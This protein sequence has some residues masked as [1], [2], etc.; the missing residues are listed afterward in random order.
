MKIQLRND[1][2]LNWESY[3]P[4][5]APGEV[6]V[7]IT[8]GKLK[9]GNGTSTWSQLDYIGSVD[10][11][12]YATT[13]QLNSEANA[14]Q[15]ADNNLQGQIDAITASSDV[16]DIVGTYAELQAYDTSKLTNAD[17][18][19]VLQDETHNDETT[20]YRWVITQNVGAW[21]LIGEEGPY[22]TKS[23]ADTKFVDLTSQ[24]EITG[25]KS[26]NNGLQSPS[27]NSPGTSRNVIKR[28][29]VGA[30]TYSI[31]IGDSAKTTG[32]YIERG[33]GQTY[34]NI[35]AGNLSSNLPT[36]T[37]S[38]LGV[39]KP[40][41]S[42]ITIDANGVIS[43]QAGGPTYTE[44]SGISI[45]NDEISV[46]TSVVR[47]VGNQSIAGNKTFTGQ[48]RG[49]LRNSNGNIVILRNGN[50]IYIG[51]NSSTKI[52]VQRDNTHYTNID[53]GNLGNY[54]S[55]VNINGGNA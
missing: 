13:T 11:S 15:L 42:T 14:R 17:I 8:V 26:F 37:A 48:L 38:N 9:V 18:V 10:L 22:Y 33:D 25:N 20:Y 40:D 4:V 23:Q 6:G 5:L 16:T 53:S 46:D 19:K 49:D 45:T 31:T 41:G 55:A 43:S 39:V 30:D 52:D 35:D 1:T 50:T 24:Q 28:D 21:S 3:N 12:G 51:D 34:T 47:T 36:A 27:I 44:G 7:D 29:M 54:I 32:V 2:T